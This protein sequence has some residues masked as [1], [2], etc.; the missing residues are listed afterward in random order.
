MPGRV[1]KYLD[2]SNTKNFNEARELI[3][4]EKNKHSSNPKLFTVELRGGIPREYWNEFVNFPPIF[5]NVHIKYDRE[6]LGDYTYDYM[7]DNKMIKEESKVKSVRKLT[8][9]LECREETQV[10]SSYYLWFLID[11]CHFEID[12]IISITTYNSHTA[13]NKFVTEFS[14]KRWQAMEKDISA[15]SNFFKTNLNGSYGYDGM[16]EEKFNRVSIKDKHKTFRSQ[17]QENFMDSRKLNDEKYIVSEKPKI[18]KCNTCLQ[19]AVFTLDNAK[20]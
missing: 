5:R 17:M 3:Y 2:C 12:D 6:T 19:E 7:I 13:F 15:L 16:N 18:Y 1:L 10:F 9:L 20:Y 14:W 4:D 8:Q 11:R